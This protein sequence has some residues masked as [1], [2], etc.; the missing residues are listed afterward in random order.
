MMVHP[1]PVML[2]LAGVA[3]FMYY[4]AEKEGVEGGYIIHVKLLP[5]K[6]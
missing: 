3:T 4:L 5:L 2:A 1:V 6:N